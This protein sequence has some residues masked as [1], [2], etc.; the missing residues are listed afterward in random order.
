MNESEEAAL[1]RRYQSGD[2]EAFRMLV[3]QYRSA[4]Y[5]TAYLMTRDRSSAEDAVQETL[6]QMWKH[7]PSLRLHGSIRF[8]LIRIVV[9]EVKQQFRKKRIP[10]VPL[11]QVP[12]M[13]DNINTAETAIMRDEERR[14]L[15]QAL[16]V[17]PSE[18]R[19]AVVLRY[20]SDLTVPEVARVL[21]EREGTI[22]SRLS[23]ALDRLGEILGGDKER[24]V[25][26]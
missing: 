2:K 24:E 23:R 1:V 21:G 18:Q 10:T 26:R 12:E 8:W 20:F 5:G 15:K 11:E 13:I 25:G 19:E 7:L 3:E 4:L 9:N 22:K 17:L 14:Q 6:I 16:E